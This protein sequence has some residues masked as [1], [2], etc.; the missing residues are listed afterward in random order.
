MR[1]IGSSRT[2]SLE[3]LGIVDR[4]LAQDQQQQLEM[5]DVS[6]SDQGHQVRL[7][8]VISGSQAQQLCQT[9]ACLQAVG[10]QLMQ[11][12]EPLDRIAESIESI[13]IKRPG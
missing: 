12:G 1:V 3:Y 8:F 6:E 5:R 11:N 4:L 2:E 13:S 9:T 10:V 7:G